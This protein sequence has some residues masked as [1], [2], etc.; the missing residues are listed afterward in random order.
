MRRKATLVLVAAAIACSVEVGQLVVAPPARAGVGGIACKL[1]GT[2]GEGWMGKACNGALDVGGRIVGGGKKVAKVLGN[3]LVQRGAA[4]AAIL[5]FVLGGAKWTMDHMAGVISST[6]SPT[7]TAGWFT[8]VYLR[9][10]AI[11]VFFALLFLCAAATEAMLRSD[12]ALITR[13]AFA[14]LPLSLLL[15]AVAAPI[16]MLLLAAS[17]ELSSGLANVAGNGTT[18]FL[19]GTSAWVLGGLTVAD[20]FFAVMAGG[21]VVAAGG[22]LWV[23]M[24]LREIAVYV[25]AAMLPL[26]FAAMVWPARRVWA[27]RTIEVLVALIL[28]KI[29]IVV[30]LA[31]G[32]AAL[33]H[34]GTSGISKLLGGLALVILGAFSPWLLLRLIPMAEV[35][36]AAVGHMRGHIHATAGL[37][38][39]E[40]ALAAHAAGRTGGAHH[41]GSGDGWRGADGAAGGFAISEFLDQ[42]QRRAAAAHDPGDQANPTA[43]TATPPPTAGSVFP[44]RVAAPDANGDQPPSSHEDTPSGGEPTERLTLPQTEQGQLLL[45]REDGGWEPLDRADD[46]PPAP[47]AAGARTDLPAIEPDENE[48]G[49]APD[50]VPDPRDAALGGSEDGQGEPS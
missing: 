8:G 19:T 4:L 49:A 35:A 3:P 14:Y 20:P 38:T 47:F 2:I 17:D 43:P 23:E 32:G 26:V 30:V 31:L 11:A 37:R 50:S 21:L 44:G 7:L 34:A 22:A 15:T 39:P 28:S 27:T 13:A 24:L 18:H 25:V 16:A 9:V 45:E 41:S 46:D 6:T 29:A 48:Q 40:A 33:D 12:M 5:A 1:I 36:S 10:E 42:M